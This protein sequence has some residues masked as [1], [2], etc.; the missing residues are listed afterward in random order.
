[1]GLVSGNGM[2]ESSWQ[3]EGGNDEKELDELY[4]KVELV[5]RRVA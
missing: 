3:Q 4:D 1:M 2:L 5:T